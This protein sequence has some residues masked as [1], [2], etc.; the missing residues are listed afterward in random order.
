MTQIW[1]NRVKCDVSTKLG[2]WVFTLKSN[3]DTPGWVQRNT[4]L[5]HAVTARPSLGLN[6]A[7]KNKTFSE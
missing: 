4:E 7:R 2:T 3:V 1:R 5:V 6:K